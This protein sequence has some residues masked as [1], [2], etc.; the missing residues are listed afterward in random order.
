[1]IL[2]DIFAD[3][4]T[5]NQAVRYDVILLCVVVYMLAIWG[6]VSVWVMS[7]A[8]NRYEKRSVA[9]L[10]GVLVF[11]FNFPVLLVYL[12]VRPEELWVKELQDEMRGEKQAIA[13]IPLATFTD[14]N[15]DLQLNM[16]IRKSAFM[17][18]SV[19]PAVSESTSNDSIPR[20]STRE[21]LFNKF[22]QKLSEKQ[23]SIAKSLKEAKLQSP[24]EQAQQAEP[25]KPV[26][27]ALIEASENIGVV[28]EVNSTNDN[29]SDKSLEYKNKKK[30]K[31]RK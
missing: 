22:R 12:L 19:K 23:S 27:N 2:S 21:N 15:G 29:V 20:I 28:N 7:D 31:R 16:V 18:S 10:W 25:V 26:V 11:M 24:V 14:E 3:V 5:K 1:M 6:I 4:L 9:Y 8:A 13:D 17:Q 30:K